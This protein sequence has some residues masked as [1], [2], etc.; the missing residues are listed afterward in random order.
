MSFSI[1]Y[2]L[3]SE[4][5]RRLELISKTDGYLQVLRMNKEWSSLL[6]KRARV[7]EAVGSIGIEGTVITLDQAKAITVGEE[8]VIVGEKERREFLGYYESLDFIKKEIESPLTTSLLLRI[9]EKITTGDEKAFPGNIRKDLRAVS[10][11]GVVIYTAPPPDQLNFLLEEFIK[12]F[13]IFADKKDFS[14]VV[15]A[16]LCHFWFVWIHPFCDGNGRVSRLLTTFLL[17]KKK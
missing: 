3:N 13:N 10:K 7:Q 5:I 8:D 9:H 17:L 1:N 12:W 11:D 15:A 14:P 16:S 2:N 6:E 4:D